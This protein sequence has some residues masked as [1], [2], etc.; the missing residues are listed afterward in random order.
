MPG[1]IPLPS[2][3][4]LYVG[5]YDI[6]RITITSGGV[7]ASYKPPPFRP[8]FYRVIELQLGQTYAIDLGGRGDT[9]F[10]CCSGGAIRYFAYYNST[11][12]VF[13]LTN[14]R[15]PSYFLRD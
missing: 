15:S 1:D 6:D 10:T 9:T 5:N 11:N 13:A 12:G 3:P 7:I 2:Q 4:T 8:A 14:D